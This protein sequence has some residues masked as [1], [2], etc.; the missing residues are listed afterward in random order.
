MKKFI[1]TDNWY[2]LAAENETGISEISAGI[3]DMIK[4]Q[5]DLGKEFKEAYE[6]N[7]HRLYKE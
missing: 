3:T 6:K 7:K 4:N 1:A 5:E 2:K